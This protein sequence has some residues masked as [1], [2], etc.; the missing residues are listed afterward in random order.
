M[1]SQE[2]VA[3][4]QA[5]GVAGVGKHTQAGLNLCSEGLAH[6][7]R[8]GAAEQSGSHGEPENKVVKP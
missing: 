7:G 5:E 1:A 6:H 8:E 4:K 2:Y 3:T